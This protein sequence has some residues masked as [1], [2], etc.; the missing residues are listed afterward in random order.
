VALLLAGGL[1]V[2]TGARADVLLG[3]DGRIA[4][5]AAPGAL[6]AG[7]AE[8]IAC[9]DRLV[10]PGLVNAHF[11]SSE[12]WSKGRFDRLPLEPW[13]LYAYPAALA[14]VQSADEIRLRTQLGAIALLRGGTTCVVDFLYELAG[15]TLDTL[16]AVVGGYRDAGLR[17]LVVLGMA[18]LPWRATVELDG[19]AIGGAVASALDAAPVVAWDEWRAFAREAVAHHHRPREGIAI[20]LGPSGPQRCSDAMLAGCAALALEL[21]VLVHTHVLETPMQAHSARRR[22]GTTM[23]RALDELGALAAPTCFAHAIWLDEEDPALMARRGV[24]VIHNPASNLKLGSGVCDVRGLR[25]TGLAVGLGTDG[26]SS[27]DSADQLEGMRLAAL[28]HRGPH[29]DFG[30]D[31]GW[32]GASEALELATTGS[33]AATPWA[34]ELGEIRPGACADIL[35]FDL[36]HHALSPLNDPVTQLV[37]TAPAGALTDVVVAGRRVVRDGAIATLDEVAVLAQARQAGP[38]VLRR[39]AAADRLADELLAAVTG[40]WQAVRAGNDPGGRR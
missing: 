10:V 39:F 16:A 5:V 34:G 19:T 18:D 36:D 8:R 32:L 2:T 9:A 24:A 31:G 3:D 23:P 13:M 21:G 4:A 25:A 17:A 15:L 27:C 14:P 30:R 40:G 28:L 26:S 6:P 11:H 1:L 20:A 29:D 37:H 38:G 7:D 35:L 12:N 33:A 22:W